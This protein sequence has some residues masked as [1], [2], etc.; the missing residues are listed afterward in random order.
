MLV[1]SLGGSLVA[2]NSP[3]E[4]LFI[5]IKD[6]IGF[7]IPNPSYS[8]LQRIQAPFAAAFDKESVS[9]RNASQSLFEVAQAINT[10]DVTNIVSNQIRKNSTGY[11]ILNYVNTLGNL[12]LRPYLR[13]FF[14]PEELESLASDILN[15]INN[16][17]T[18]L[19]MKI[20]NDISYKVKSKNWY[21][22]KEADSYN[23][24]YTAEINNAFN[25]LL[26]KIEDIK[27]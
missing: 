1:S 19:S 24:Q 3:F 11:N 9:I 18:R 5:S 22:T 16:P 23:N 21:V 15:L 12:S 26:Q 20:I 17:T 8:N 6:Q 2:P 13:V 7:K 10:P 4:G 27:K 14:S 25:T